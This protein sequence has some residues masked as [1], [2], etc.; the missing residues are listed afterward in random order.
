MTILIDIPT[1]VLR[2]AEILWDFHVVSAPLVPADFIL[3]LGS[4]DERVAAH[5]AQ[6]CLQGL[7]P[8]LV[9]SGG[10]GKVT[11]EA[12][13]GHAESEGERFARIAMAAGVLADRIL[14][15]PMAANTGDNITL[16]RQLLADRGL[17]VGR[18]ILVTKPYMARRAL[19]TA[20]KQWSEIAWQVSVP[21]IPFLLYPRAD[22]PLDTMIHLMVGDTQ[23]L[24][25]YADAGY[26][27][28][29]D[30]PDEVWAAYE[31]LRNAGYNN[32]VIQGG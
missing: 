20:Q 6:L 30:I 29:V 17:A 12:W 31:R 26:Q 10:R 7:A 15:E 3:A 9:C 4:H 11:T 13:T 22:V 21:A 18:G 5:A 19:A 32:Y 25:V 1:D 16:T 23:R 27:A 24:R 28:P 2:D 14:V 8:L